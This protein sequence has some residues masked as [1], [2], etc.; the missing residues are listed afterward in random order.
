VRRLRPA[1]RFQ[2]LD[3]GA[4]SAGGEDWCAGCR[5]KRIDALNQAAAA[6]GTILTH[7]IGTRPR[8]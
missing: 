5:R 4:N 1:D 7:S 3:R 8:R 6:R 2:L